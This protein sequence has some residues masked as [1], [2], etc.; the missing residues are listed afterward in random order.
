ML[1]DTQFM[2]YAYGISIFILNHLLYLINKKLFKSLNTTKYERATRL[3]IICVYISGFLLWD[4]SN[5]LLTFKVTFYGSIKEN[6]RKGLIQHQFFLFLL[7]SLQ[8]YFV[9]YFLN[10]NTYFGLATFDIKGQKIACLKKQNF[11]RDN[12]CI[13]NITLCHLAL[14]H[15]LLV[16]ATFNFVVNSRIRGMMYWKCIFVWK[17]DEK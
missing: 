5:K 10:H 9:Q 17:N 8:T 2:F 6:R 4:E 1:L 12:F 13:K 11:S 14:R 3:N 15:F 7:L 16:V